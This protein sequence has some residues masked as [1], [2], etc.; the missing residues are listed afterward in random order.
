MNPAEQIRPD[1]FLDEDSHTSKQE[2]DPLDESDMEML[3]APLNIEDLDSPASADGTSSEEASFAEA[4][5]PS[6]RG[7][8]DV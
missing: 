6:P 7:A 5:P 2:D 1:T 4:R 3:Q 8:A